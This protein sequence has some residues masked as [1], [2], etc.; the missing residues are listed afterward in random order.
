MRALLRGGAGEQ[1]EIA[2]RIAHDEGASAPRLLLQRPEEIDAGRLKLEK[3]LV[4]VGGAAD[5][6]GGRQQL[7]ALPDVAH[8]DRL[9][10]QP[11]IDR[12]LVAA[13]LTVEGRLAVGEDD[14]E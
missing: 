14:L 6:E 9:A 10:D 7:L 11:E 13:D 5:V 3:Q 4:N 2:V 1:Q 12:S 8:I